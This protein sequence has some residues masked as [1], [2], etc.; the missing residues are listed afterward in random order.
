MN[1]LLSLQRN[2]TLF[3][4]VWS[5]IRRPGPF[6]NKQKWSGNHKMS[7]TSAAA[8]AAMHTVLSGA[9]ENQKP[10]PP[11]AKVNAT[12]SGGYSHIAES[13]LHA[14]HDDPLRHSLGNSMNATNSA[15]SG[16]IPL[17]PL[18]LYDT[19]INRGPTK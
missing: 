8:S 3:G 9:N 17:R 11:K 12:L 7:A 18:V 16:D 2:H 5:S 15:A 1:A 10:E 14:V 13:I 19:T 4:N 6:G